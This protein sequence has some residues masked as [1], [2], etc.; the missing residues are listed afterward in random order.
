M[1][2]WVEFRY[3]PA[4][5]GQKVEEKY[6]SAEAVA[7][8]EHSREDQEILGVYTPFTAEYLAHLS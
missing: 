1:S 5:A 3:A 7:F 4:R 8:V 2:I 6:A